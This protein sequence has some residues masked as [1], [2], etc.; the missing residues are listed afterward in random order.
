MFVVSFVPAS[1]PPPPA[2]A[3]PP[4]QAESEADF[5]KRLSRIRAD[6]EARQE[7]ARG[8]ARHRLTVPGTY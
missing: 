5:L 1:G 6:A 8:A 4:R 7:A 3:T 2:P